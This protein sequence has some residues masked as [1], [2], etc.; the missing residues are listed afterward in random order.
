MIDCDLFVYFLQ[1]KTGHDVK[2][3][4]DFRHY[5]VTGDHPCVE[6]FLTPEG[7]IPPSSLTV[8]VNFSQ[9]G[10]PK[11]EALLGPAVALCLIAVMTGLPLPSRKL[12]LAGALGVAGTLEGGLEPGLPE[13]ELRLPNLLQSEEC[14]FDMNGLPSDTYDRWVQGGGLNMAGVEVKRVK[15]IWE[16]MEVV[17]G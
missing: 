8:I 4:V 3:L 2:Q 7:A 12:T 11:K 13:V 9:V 14:H 15:T 6:D 16:V 17:W 10:I 5:C 1:D